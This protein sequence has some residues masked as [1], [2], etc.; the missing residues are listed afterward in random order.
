MDDI[1]LMLKDIQR[2]VTAIEQSVAP[3]DLH[4]TL[5]KS[6]YSCRE[7]A[8]LTRKFGTK[9]AQEF[10]VRLACCDGRIPEAEK[11][12][13]GRWRIPREAVLRILSVGLPPERRHRG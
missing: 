5:S 8:E 10:T 1:R 12:D 9:K 13:D 11:F 3:P 6:H 2:R 7:T 4:R